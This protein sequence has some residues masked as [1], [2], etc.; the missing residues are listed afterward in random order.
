[1][2]YPDTKM[3]VAANLWIR[4]MYFAK[5]GD[6]NEGHIHNFDHL[7]LLANGSVK[8]NV[9]GNE[10]IFKAP[11]IFLTQAGKRHFIEA[12]EDNTVAYCVHAL[13]NA[14]SKESE[15]LM[16]DQIPN[17]LNLINSGIAKPL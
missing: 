6:K 3:T 13:R 17:G 8:V 7:T 1:M 14:E 2:A 16:P 12:L 9:D 15:I 5:T 10:T 11:H 4:Q